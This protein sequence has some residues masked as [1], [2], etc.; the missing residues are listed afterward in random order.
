ME[1]IIHGFSITHHTNYHLKILVTV[2]TYRSGYPSGYESRA[3]QVDISS[4]LR[5]WVGAHPGPRWQCS[6]DRE[7]PEVA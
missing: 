7:E 6:A 2:P 4:V 1:P 3:V 5:P